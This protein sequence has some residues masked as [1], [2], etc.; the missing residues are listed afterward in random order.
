MKEDLLFHTPTGSQSPPSGCLFI[1]RLSYFYDFKKESVT[2]PLRRPVLYKKAQQ[3]YN[4]LILFL[5]LQK[6]TDHNQKVFA[7][8][9]F[10]LQLCQ[11][12]LQSIL[13][14]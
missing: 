8:F 4:V 5:N 12:N 11:Y 1:S 13:C 9:F 2:L 6:L 14:L 3:F 10:S 7:Y